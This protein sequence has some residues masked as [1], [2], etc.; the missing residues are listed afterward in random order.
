MKNRIYLKQLESYQYASEKAKKRMGDNPYFD[1]ELLPTVTMQEEMKLYI[2][3]RS[4]EISSEKLYSEK[5]F[6]NHLCQLIQ[7]KGKELNSFCDW[8]KER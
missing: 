5:R 2:V 1:L 3:A 8:E 4:Q 7:E 6:Y